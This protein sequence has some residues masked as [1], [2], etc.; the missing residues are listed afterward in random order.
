[1]M[2]A[3]ATTVRGVIGSLSSTEP[4]N[5]ATI[6]LTYVYVETRVSGATMIS[7]P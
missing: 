2:T 4:R 7:Q 1:M 3:A 5:T 6:G